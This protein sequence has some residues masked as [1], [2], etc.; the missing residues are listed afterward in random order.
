MKAD[1]HRGLD[2][3]K[4]MKLIGHCEQCGGKFTTDQIGQ[5][6]C[7]ACRQIAVSVKNL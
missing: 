7:P 4:I 1:I 5:S 3:V 2:D 6:R